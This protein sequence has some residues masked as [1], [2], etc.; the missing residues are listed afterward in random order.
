MKKKDLVPGTIYSPKNSAPYLLLSTGI[1]RS[2]RAYTGPSQYFLKEQGAKP[3]RG[4]GYSDFGQGVLALGG[5]YETMLALQEHHAEAIKKIA[6]LEPGD[7]TRE[8]TEEVQALL[9]L[10]KEQNTEGFV[11]TRLENYQRWAGTYDE[12]REAEDERSRRLHNAFD[13]LG[14]FQD[15]ARRHADGLEDRVRAL[16]EEHMHLGRVTSRRNSTNGEHSSY[17]VSGLELPFSRLERLLELAEK[18]REAEAGLTDPTGDFVT[19]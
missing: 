6:D 16:L 5:S 9:S 10:A 17:V 15:E 1:W 14:K 8:H 13:E 11:Y 3:Q 7:R 4:H 19:E 12:V 18:G 2:P